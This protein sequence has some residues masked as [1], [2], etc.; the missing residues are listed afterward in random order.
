MRLINYNELFSNYLIFN[1]LQ[2]LKGLKFKENY[3]ALLSYLP[4]A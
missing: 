1:Y 3:Y 2:F 4:Q